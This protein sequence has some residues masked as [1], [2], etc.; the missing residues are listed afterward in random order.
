MEQQFY[1]LIQFLPNNV[2]TFED[3][4]RKTCELGI[5]AIYP[6]YGD[7]SEPK[8]WTKEIWGKRTDRFQRILIE[9]CKQ[10]KNPFLP[11]IYEPKY[12][13]QLSVEDLGCCFHGSLNVEKKIPLDATRSSKISCII[14]PEG[15]FSS[16]EELVLSKLSHGVCLPTCVLRVETAVV[17]LISVLK[18]LV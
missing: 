5:S 17:G 12:L 15:G 8:H 18:T 11:K 7:R 4:L 6:I 16:Q 2:A 10:A 14:G 1:Q 9:S 3:I 13:N